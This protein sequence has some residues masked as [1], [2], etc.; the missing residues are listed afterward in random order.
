MRKYINKYAVIGLF[1]CFLFQFVSWGVSS[2][3]FKYFFNGK[4]AEGQDIT[5]AQF[6]LNWGPD[7]YITEGFNIMQLALPLLTTIAAC[8]IMRL[9][10]G[11]YENAKPR[12]MHYS[13]YV[14]HDI[15][16][17]SLFSAL[18]IFIGFLLFYLFG[19]I[20][21]PV[22][23]DSAY[24]RSFLNYEF[25]DGFAKKDPLAYY[26]IEGV[27]KFF[28]FPFFYGI[29]ACCSYLFFRKKFSGVIVPVGYFYLLTILCATMR[30]SLHGTLA[31]ELVQA[32]RPDRM[33]MMGGE[34]GS[35]YPMA[36]PF[37]SLIPPIIASVVFF[38][39]GVKNEK[40][41]G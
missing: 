40:K 9:C 7:Y 5:Q 30:N 27:Y 3:F 33:I 35:G 4:I 38:I 36:Y 24:E 28:L 23:Y 39:L 32:I 26:L 8:E 19:A 2:S 21:C 15:V 22:D 31:G 29:F 12:I 14:A 20:N 37:N 16:L 17:I 25:G 34:V 13:R 6:I 11:Y 41:N 1:C 18:A 10:S